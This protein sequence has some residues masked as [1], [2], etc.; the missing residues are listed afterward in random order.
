MTLDK[1]ATFRIMIRLFGVRPG[2]MTGGGMATQTLQP[3]AALIVLGGTLGAVMVQFPVR[4]L[5]QA[6]MHLKDL[7]L[8]RHPMPDS[9]LQH[10][11]RY[12]YKVRMEGLLSLDKELV[13]IQ[14][15]LSA[16][17]PHAGH[18]RR[19]ARRPA[20]EDRAAA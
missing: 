16:R 11:L 12:A 6:L 13:K 3:A 1:N 10:L 4:A 5:A 19:Q 15:S 9:L 7:F 8:Q 2:A 17:E 20:Q 14:D 18:R